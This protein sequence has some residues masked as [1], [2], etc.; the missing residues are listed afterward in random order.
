M[1]AN[2]MKM[3]L[4]TIVIASSV[5]GVSGIVSSASADTRKETNQSYLSLPITVGGQSETADDDSGDD[6]GPPPAV[7]RNEKSHGA[8]SED[9]DWTTADNNTIPE[10]YMKGL[11]NCETTAA[12]DGHLTLVEIMDC[13]YQVF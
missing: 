10:K 2:R 7:L 8:T 5:I 3:A 6:D 12:A 9:S 11:S 1:F 13:F 4:L